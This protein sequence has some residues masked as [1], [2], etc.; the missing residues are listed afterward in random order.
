MRLW[1]VSLSLGL[2]M[3]ACGGGGTG[4]DSSADTDPG[5]ASESGSTGTAS[6][7]G[8]ATAEPTTEVA[9]TTGGPTS[10]G[11]T[12]EA[13]PTATTAVDPTATSGDETTGTSGD[14][15]TGT[16]GDETTGTS[17]VPAICGDGKLDPGE[18]CDDGN[19]ND[20]DD[21]S[22]TC[23]QASCSDGIKNAAETDVDCGGPTCDTCAL[24]EQCGGNADCASGLCQAGVC[25]AVT[26]TLPNCAAANVTSMQAYTGV[27]MANCGCHAGGSGGLTITSAATLKA[28]TVDV[29]A[30]TAKMKRITPNDV[31]QSYLLYKIL[32]QHLK[33]PGGGGSQMPGQALTDPQKCLLI[34]WVKSG[35]N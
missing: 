31:D 21:C 16:S 32:N 34:N 15:S 11:P 7:T 18:A 6:T 2:T 33:V 19:Q 25:S 24:G 30:T 4:S 20:A 26:L 3:S 10:D 22:N 17:D 23:Q 27:V 9:P 14:E 5:T 8:E 29:N 1:I 13:D 35:A 12:T 28:N